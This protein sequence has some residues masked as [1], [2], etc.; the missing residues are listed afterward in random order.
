[1][2]TQ[3]KNGESKH[4]TTPQVDATKKVDAVAPTA[5]QKDTK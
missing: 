3:N 1:M 5:G 2:D 4:A